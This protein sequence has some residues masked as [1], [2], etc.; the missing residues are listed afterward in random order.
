MHLLA[1][2]DHVVSDIITPALDRRFGVERVTLLCHRPDLGFAY[3]VAG[4]ARNAHLPVAVEVIPPDH[5]PL[6][7]QQRLAELAQGVCCFN[8]SAASPV[9]AALAYEVARQQQLPVMSVDHATDR[10]IWLSGGE[11][12]AVG[13]G[14]DIADGLSLEGYFGLYGSRVVGM[15]YRLST[16][17][18]RLEALASDLAQWAV[19]HPRDVS[20]LNRLCNELAADGYSRRPLPRGEQS[21]HDWLAA[22]GMVSFRHGGHMRCHDARARFFLAGGWLE[23]WL[24]SRVAELAGHLPISD[25][26]V[27][28]KISHDG[29]ENEFDVALISNNRL[30]LIECKTT[31]ATGLHH[32]GVGVDH[33]FKL[34]SAATLGGLDAHAML[35]SLYPPSES[36]RARAQTQGIALLAAPDFPRARAF[37]EEWLRG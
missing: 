16:R 24:L 8:L 2:V 29:V 3:D 28:V 20:T 6:A 30:F 4:V 37:L 13:N 14:T 12:V 18:P 33:L 22:T 27:G 32:R 15:H 17:Q 10:L 36:E 23:V 21:L 9:Q 34:D 5:Q 26:A 31:A 35:A 19:R 11:R 7:L 25:A 1:F